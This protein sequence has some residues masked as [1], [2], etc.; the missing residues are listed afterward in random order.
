M[1]FFLVYGFVRSQLTSKNE[2]DLTEGCIRALGRGG[3]IVKFQL[4]ICIF[5]RLINI[6]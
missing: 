5:K 3:L 6:N 1:Q 2:R 4:S